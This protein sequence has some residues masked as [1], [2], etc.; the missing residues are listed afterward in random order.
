MAESVF[1]RQLAKLRKEKGVT[2]EQIADYLGVSPQ[3]ISKWENGSYPNGDLLPRLADYFEV[4]IDYLYGR[5][6]KEVPLEQQIV[7]AIQS[8]EGNEEWDYGARMEQMFRYIWAM[9]IGCWPD[10]KYYYER[11]GDMNSITVSSVTNKSGFSFMRLN[12]DLEFYA[13]MKEPEEG[14]AS[15]FKETEE[16]TKL[17]EILGRKGNLQVLFYVLSLENGEC[18]SA[19]TIAGYLKLPIEGVQEILDYLCSLSECGNGML[20]TLS[21]IGKNDRKEKVYAKVEASSAVAL[22]LLA[23]ADSI[24][25]PP[26][27]FTIQIGAR[28]QGWM[29]R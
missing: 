16:L 26:Q 11:N 5:E 18:V 24:I 28:G 8:T 17:F 3:A 9:Q 29:D 12:K 20:V 14:F 27:N 6:K 25:N 10:N 7:E 19:A 23:A 22:L 13:L 2:Q 1:G 4:S 15:Y 21:V